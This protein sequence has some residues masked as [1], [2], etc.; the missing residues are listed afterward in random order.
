MGISLKLR[1][2]IKNSVCYSPLL[3]V[4]KM[5]AFKMTVIINAA[6]ACCCIHLSGA[7]KHRD[8]TRVFSSVQKKQ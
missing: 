1:I 6:G 2:F 5:F 7:R 8:E 4:I 3:R